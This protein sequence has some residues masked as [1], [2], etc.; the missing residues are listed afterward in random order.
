[1]LS[2]LPKKKRLRRLSSSKQTVELSFAYLLLL[3]NMD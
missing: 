1:V 2:I 3:D